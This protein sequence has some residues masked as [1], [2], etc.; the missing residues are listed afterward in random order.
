MTVVLPTL[1]QYCRCTTL[2]NVEVV[3]WSFTAFI[4]SRLDCCNSLLYGV[5]HSLIRKV[6]SIPNATVRLLVCTRRGD[7]MSPVLLRSCTGFQFRDESTSNWRALSSCLC[8]AKHL[9]T[10]LMTY[11]WSRK[12]LD[13]GCVRLPTDRVLFHAPTTRSATEVLLPPGHASGTASQHTYTTK[14]LFTEHLG[15]KMHKF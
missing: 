4:A 14:T 12:V 11:T 8:P 15:V 5:S 13:V 2:W 10:W 1:S 9:R 6:Q 7:H 3:V